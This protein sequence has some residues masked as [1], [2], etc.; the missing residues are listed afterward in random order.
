M[1]MMIHT[2]IQNNFRGIININTI[3]TDV[4]FRRHAPYG[5]RNVVPSLTGVYASPA[6]LVGVYTLP[7]PMGR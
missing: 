4:Y 6:V 7:A 1:M 5:R 3:A 2:N